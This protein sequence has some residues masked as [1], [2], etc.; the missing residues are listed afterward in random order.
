MTALIHVLAGDRLVLGESPIWDNLHQ[1]FYAVDIERRRIHRWR[2]GSEDHAFW[3]L[4]Q[5]V[6]CISLTDRG[7]LLAAMETEIVEV[8][9]DSEK[10]TLST[11]AQLTHPAPS[12]RFNDGRCD[13][14]GR[15]WV[16]TMCTDG[17]V[18]TA[19]G[20]L[21]CLDERGLTGP[22]VKELRTPNGLAVSPDGKTLYLSDSHPSS[23][24]IW[25]MALDEPTGALGPRVDYFNMRNMAGRP[26]GAAMDSDGNYW[27]CGND[28]SVVYALDDQGRLIHSIQVPQRKPSMC[29]FGG[30]DMTSLI[31]ASIDARPLGWMDPWGGAVVH[32]PSPA[33]GEPEPRFSRWPRLSKTLP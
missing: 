11:I 31:V 28:G 1:C 4:P 30:P 16:G 12:M 3:D 32:L 20:G 21:Y 25:R 10:V 13:R 9:L 6:A 33:R 8:E 17:S 14:S 22:W 7:T 29:C 15:F 2:W 18:T 26:D 24:Q 19:W 27:I 23:Q 5:R